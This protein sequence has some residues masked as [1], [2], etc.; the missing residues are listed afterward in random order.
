MIIGIDLG[1]SNSAVAFLDDQ[2]NP[3]IL[4]NRE[5]ERTTASV[6]YF[7]D[8][9]VIVGSA[10]KSISVSDPANTIQFVK[11]QMGNPSFKFPA[12]N[13]E[14]YTAEELS[15]LILKKLKVD[16]EDALGHDVKKAVITVPAYFNDA[17][18]KATQDAGKIAGLDVVKVINEPTAAALAYGIRQNGDPQNI[19][20]YDL[21]GGTFDV[22]VM[23]ISENQIRVRATDGDRNLGGFDFDNELF[24]HVVDLFEEQ[25]GIDLYDDDVAMQ[26]L[27]E[28]AEAA[29]KILS[30]RTKSIL[31]ISSQGKSVKAE[32]TREMFNEM[33]S[34][35][36]GRT[37]LYMNC[38]LSEA[39][40]TWSDI[41]K[42]LLVG[43]STRIPAVIDLIE[44]E[45]GIKPSLEGNPDEVVTLGAA[46]QGKLLADKDVASPERIF[47]TNIVDVNSHS[48]GMLTNSVEENRLIN[49]IILPRNTEIPASESRV[50]YTMHDNQESLLLRITEGEN[51][52]PIDVSVIGEI[53]VDLTGDTPAGSP[54]S[55]RISFDANGV[56]QVYAVDAHHNHDLGELFIERKSNLTEK[57]V[58][59]KQQKIASLSVV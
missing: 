41:D 23:S 21:G 4:P 33:I 58:L 40:M 28:K 29:K 47:N 6:I 9:A 10:A 2:G 55:V 18:R 54:I 51:I 3:T 15:A 39:E 27:R 35:L 46:I 32:I 16:A 48:L 11:R 38:V 7:E 59:E 5:G 19:L 30:V 43:G 20:V 8:G 42:I 50:F 31:M 56:V 52:E 49:A 57:S 44:K 45:S 22:T 36:L 12:E 25:H 17:Q 13:G 53:T 34:P 14:V 24:N 37:A 1:T 26:E